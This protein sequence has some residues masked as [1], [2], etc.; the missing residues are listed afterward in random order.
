MAL[1]LAPMRVNAIH[2]GI[3]GNSPF[4][5][6]KPAGVLDGYESRTPGGELE[7]PTF[8]KVVVATHADTARALL[9]DASDDEQRHCDG[10]CNE[11]ARVDLLRHAPHHSSRS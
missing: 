2:P 3:I 10:A 8:D 9:T 4:W 6:D 11:L 1:E 5:S 7:T